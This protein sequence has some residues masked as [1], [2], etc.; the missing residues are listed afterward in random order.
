MSKYAIYILSERRI[1]PTAFTQIASTNNTVIH[2]EHEPLLCLTLV[3]FYNE[4]RVLV[5]IFMS[6]CAAD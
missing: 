4:F 5:V 2:L 6:F 1:G 3:E